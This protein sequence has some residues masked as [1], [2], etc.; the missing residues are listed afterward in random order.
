MF[1]TIGLY[2][3]EEHMDF[4]KHFVA[5]GTASLLMLA[6]QQKVEEKKPT[7][8]EIAAAEAEK[9][10][11]EAAEKTA[12]RDAAVKA[13]TE[14]ANDPRVQKTLDEKAQRAGTGFAK[15]AIS[16]A[17]KKVQALE[18]EL[19]AKRKAGEEAAVKRLEAE[20]EAAKRNFENLKK[21][22]EAQPNA[23]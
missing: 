15:G 10:T 11:R 13:F 3:L 19:E 1:Q 14:L 22:Q 8:D 21:Q 7:P 20:L 12:M 9:A 17:E 23:Q 5:L 2:N 6:C 4:R 16:E 18:K